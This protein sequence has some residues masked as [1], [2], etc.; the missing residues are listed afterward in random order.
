[1]FDF[2]LQRACDHMVF[3]EQVTLQGTSPNYFSVLNYPCDGSAN[4]ITARELSAT[5]GL[6]NFVYARDGITNW[7]LHAGNLQI[8]WNSKGLGGPGSGVASFVDG[9][10]SIEPPPAILVSYRATSDN[11]PNCSDND[12]G[13][14]KDIDFDSQGALR[15]VQGTDKLRQIL[16]KAVLTTLGANQFAPGYGSSLGASIGQKFDAFTE[17][18]IYQ[19]I[20]STV[21][22]LISQQATNGALPLNEVITGLNSLQINQDATDPRRMVIYVEIATGDFQKVGFNFSLVTG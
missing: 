19:A 17:F 21:Q 20:V 6:S 1:M 2:K 10:T 13:I 4:I 8:D 5:E 14:M 16:L 12:L 18:S 11:C 7:A 9:A 22:Y 15:E 3:D